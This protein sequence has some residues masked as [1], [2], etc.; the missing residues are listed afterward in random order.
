MPATKHHDFFEI[1]F[2]LILPH[3][4]RPSQSNPYFWDS[5]AVE[6]LATDD[7]SKT[8]IVT[9]LSIDFRDTRNAKL[10]F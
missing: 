9:L 10:R 5:Q 2:Y 3:V 7:I 1:I 6:G 8:A 4:P